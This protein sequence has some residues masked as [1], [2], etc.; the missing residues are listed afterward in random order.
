MVDRDPGQVAA[1]QVGSVRIRFLER[2]R[3]T[4]DYVADGRLVTKAIIRQP[5]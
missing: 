5:F 3:A 2:D 4:L 1:L